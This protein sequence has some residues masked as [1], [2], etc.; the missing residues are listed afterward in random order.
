MKI[1][2]LI[3]DFF[4]F[5]FF[6]CQINFYRL[7]KESQNFFELV[8]FDFLLDKSGNLFVMEVNMSPNLYAGADLVKSEETYED[9]VENVLNIIGFG[10]KTKRPTNSDLAVNSEICSNRC[11]ASCDFKECQS[12]VKCMTKE[13][14]ES[15]LKA[16]EEQMNAGEFRRVVPPSSVSY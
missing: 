16:Y 5:F 6:C 12:C 7:P 15:F 10:K 3:G 9:T 13:N 14:K 11:Q 8:R 1:F 2:R 4:D